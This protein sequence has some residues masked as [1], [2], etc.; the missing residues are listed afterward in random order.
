MWT[1]KVKTGDNSYETI[2]IPTTARLVAFLGVLEF[3][4]EVAVV[5][6]AHFKMTEA[7]QMSQA[8]S[9]GEVVHCSEDSFLPSCSNPYND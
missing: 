2:D 6:L 4:T 5:G 3:Q 9:E 8:F 7:G 1:V